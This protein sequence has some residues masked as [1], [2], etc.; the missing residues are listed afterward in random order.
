MIHKEH[1]YSLLELMALTEKH[2]DLFDKLQF[3]ENL[4]NNLQLIEITEYVKESGI[5]DKTV[6]NRIESGKLPSMFLGKTI[7]IIKTLTH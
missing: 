6:R 3:I 7:F 2:I 1:K 5:S 4:F